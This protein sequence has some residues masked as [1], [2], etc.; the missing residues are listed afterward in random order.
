MTARNDVTGDLIKTGVNSEAYRNN[1]FWDKKP[2]SK[3]ELDEQV[4]NL[5][6]YLNAATRK[7]NP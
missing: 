7:P 6:D 4:K 3:Q 1:K 5:T 2:M